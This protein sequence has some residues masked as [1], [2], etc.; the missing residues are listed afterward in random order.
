MVG[1]VIVQVVTNKTGKY[2]EVLEQQSMDRSWRSVDTQADVQ[3]HDEI[4]WQSYCGYLSRSGQ[5]K[6]KSIGSCRP[7]NSHGRS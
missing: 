5:F 3:V 4:W 1:G 7:A 2:I 6:D